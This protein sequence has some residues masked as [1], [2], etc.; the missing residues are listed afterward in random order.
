MSTDRMSRRDFLRRMGAGSVA[1]AAATLPGC[2]GGETASKETSDATLG[3][4]PTDKM[5]YRTTPSSGD[6]VSLLGYGCM[7]WPTRKEGEEEVLDQEEI[8]RLVDTALKHGVNYFD[9]SPAYCRGRS[10]EATG[11]A[12]ARH[13]RDSY[14]IATKL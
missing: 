6:K 5:T 11:I 4:I 7:R 10:E 12:L 2:G 13:P 1:A 8:N 3:P 9:T 14:F